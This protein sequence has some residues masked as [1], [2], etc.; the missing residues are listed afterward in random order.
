MRKSI[1]I[2]ILGLLIFNLSCG[3][4]EENYSELIKEAGELY[5]AKE[6]KQSAQKY[7]EAF[8]IPGETGKTVDK[9]NAACS[10]ALAKEI[11]SSFVQLY[12]IVNNRSYSNYQHL[13]TDKDLTSL[14]QI[15]GGQIF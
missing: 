10:W 13:S 9:Y 1:F 12:E 8:S 14:H 5:E 15:R 4:N 2:T 7:S 6:F 3:Q 11:D